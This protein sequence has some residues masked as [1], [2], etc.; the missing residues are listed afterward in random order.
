MLGNERGRLPKACLN[1]D[2]PVVFE[3]ANLGLKQT[4]KVLQ[5][6]S[7]LNQPF[8]LMS[9]D[10]SSYSSDP[11]LVRVG[12]SCCQPEEETRP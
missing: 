12:G 6:T 4:F 7:P 9:H 11:D 5:D 3:T 1:T 2:V 8:A 10:L